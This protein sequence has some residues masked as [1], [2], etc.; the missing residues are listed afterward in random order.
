M[1]NSLAPVEVKYSFFMSNNE[2][3]SLEPVFQLQSNGGDGS[4]STFG[5]EAPFVMT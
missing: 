1:T 4:S 3:F 2:E 5:K